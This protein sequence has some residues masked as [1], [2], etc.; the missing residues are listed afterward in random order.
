[1][2]INFW[3]N[4]PGLVMHRWVGLAEL[5]GRFLIHSGFGWFWQRLTKLRTVRWPYFSTFFT[6]FGQYFNA[7][8]LPQDSNL[9]SLWISNWASWYLFDQCIHIKVGHLLSES[10]CQNCAVEFYL[11]KLLVRCQKFQDWIQVPTRPLGYCSKR[12]LQ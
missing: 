3:A 2:H 9:P 12:L 1:M 10:W 11:A 8:D 5:S 7:E 4:I 6:C